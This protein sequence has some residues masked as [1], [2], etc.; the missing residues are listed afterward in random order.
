MVVLLWLS[1]GVIFCAF[2]LTYMHKK[3]LLLH[4][5]V[6]AVALPITKICKS[7][8]NERANNCQLFVIGVNC[9]ISTDEIGVSVL[10]VQNMYSGF[11]YALSLS[12]TKTHYGLSADN[13]TAKIQQNFQTA[14]QSVHF[15]YFYLP[16]FVVLC[17]ILT[18][19]TTFAYRAQ[20]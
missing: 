16:I 7:S 2:V 19:H 4:I 3:V 15:L 20:R 8:T 11:C 12:R 17:R 5:S 6:E 14:K 13:P 9:Y 18:M 1:C 10:I